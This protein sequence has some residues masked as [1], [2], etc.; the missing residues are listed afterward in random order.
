[1]NKSYCCEAANIK[2]RYV[3]GQALIR[4]SHKN[5]GSI[6]A[7]PSLCSDHSFLCETKY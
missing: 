5:K 1:M 6:T 4:V 2:N 3:M 7:V